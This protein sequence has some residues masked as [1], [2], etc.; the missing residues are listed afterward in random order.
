MGSDITV[1]QA[2]MSEQVDEVPVEEYYRHKA[3]GQTH[4]Q[5]EHPCP[6][7]GCTKSYSRKSD[8][9]RHLRKSHPLQADKHIHVKF[10]SNNNKLC[11]A[12]NTHLKTISQALLDPVNRE[13]IA[14]HVAQFSSSCCEVDL[15]CGINS[16]L[17]SAL[18]SERQEWQQ[19]M[20]EAG[21]RQKWWE[22]FLSVKPAE[23]VELEKLLELEP[24]VEPDI[25]KAE[26]LEYY[27][28]ISDDE[29]EEVLEDYKTLESTCTQS[30]EPI[31]YDDGS[32]GWREA[33]PEE[34]L[35]EVPPSEEEF[36]AIQARMV[37]YKSGSSSQLSP[38]P[39]QNKRKQ[40]SD[41]EEDE[42]EDEEENK[43]DDKEEGKGEAPQFFTFI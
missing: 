43:D 6:I 42:L 21:G 13:L 1:I 41:S 4:E 29:L 20:Q 10:T 27:Q 16:K 19:Q 18:E 24:S 2:D 28:D 31:W 34:L 36:Q 7:E 37:R 39:Q 17:D 38:P 15:S 30:S 35:K 14:Q 5:L 3:A 12:I 9:N 26:N 22:L 33:A 32:G 23:L 11:T 8:L 40:G 25:S